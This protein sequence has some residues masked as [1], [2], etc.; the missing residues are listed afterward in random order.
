MDRFK[1]DLRHSTGYT[2][3]EIMIATLIMFFIVG[4]GVAAYRQF[5]ERQAL[6]NYGRNLAI[7]LRETQKKA[8]S[9][10]KPDS[11]RST[12]SGQ[13]D[14]ELEAWQIEVKDRD[15]YVI[16]VL[17]GGQKY[18]ISDS[19]NLES[20]LLFSSNDQGK[21]VTFEVLTGKVTNLQSRTLTLTSGNRSFRIDVSPVGG[22]SEST[23]N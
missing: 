6:T 14:K 18:Q 5:D 3:I 17:C 22:I 4:G 8:Q 15:T 10:E 13:S 9:G 1:T 11:C 16:N 21:N 2:L 19:I 20:N 7:D 12:Q 23:G